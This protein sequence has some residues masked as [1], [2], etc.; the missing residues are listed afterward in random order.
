[1]AAPMIDPNGLQ[2]IL[3]LLQES[4]SNDS[5]TQKNVQI[6]LEQYNQIPDFNS[7][8]I[9]ILT[10]QR[11]Q[12]V[13]TRSLAGLILK[14]NVRMYYSNFPSQVADFIKAECLNCVGDS[15][16]LIRA[17][18]GILITTICSRDPLSMT[19]F[20]PHLLN[21]CDS[22]NDDVV[23][24]AINALQKV[25]E[26]SSQT[27]MHMEG[28]PLSHMIPKFLQLCSHQR[29]KVREL[30]ISAL[31]Q[32]ILD[33]ATAL[34]QH[35]EHFVQ[36]LFG[37]A[38]DPDTGV[39]KNVCQALV[40]LLEVRID[41]LMPQ[42][43]NVIEYMLMSTQDAD[44]NVALESCEFWLAFA[45][46]ETARPCLEP[47][48]GRL[49]PVLV[50]GMRYSEED[51]ILLK[52][53]VEDDEMVPD[54]EED[55]APRHAKTKKTHG[56]MGQVPGQPEDGEDSDDEDGEDGMGDQSMDWNLRKCSAAA[57]DMLASVFQEA[58]LPFLLPLIER[59]LQSQDWIH[60]EC[61]IL[62]LGA[63]SEG[64]MNGM[65][66][67][68]PD[69]VIFLIKHCLTHKRALVRSITC[70]TL[71]RY[72]QWIVNAPA[73]NDRHFPYFQCLMEGL[74]TCV[75]DHN[76]RVQE[77]ACSA[78]ATL[79]EEACTELVPYLD[80]ILERLVA[81]FSKYQ[82]KNLLILYDAIGTLADCVGAPLNH[83]RYIQM[84]MPPLIEKWNGLTDEDRDL[85]PLLECLSSVATALGM[86]FLPYAPR[87]YERCL[88]LVQNTL[89]GY[90]YLDN[91]PQN[92]DYV[93]PDKDFMIVALDLLSGVTE[94]LGQNVESLVANSNLLPLLYECMQ[95]PVAE[96]RQS[97]F[98]L[99]GDLTKAC[100]VHV[101]PYIHNFLPVVARNLDP[102]FISVCNNACWAIGEIAMKLGDEIKPYIQAILQNLIT[103]INKENTPKTLSENC[104]I[105]IGRLGLVCPPDVAPHLELF[106][107]PWCLSL[108]N[109]R[110]NA[111]KDSAFRGVCA[112][113]LVNPKGVVQPF[114]YFCDAVASWSNP[115]DDL[116]A[117]FHRILHGFKSSVGED[118]WKQYFD[119]FPPPLRNKLVETYNL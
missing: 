44:D 114:I 12:E 34:M 78:F 33:R 29:G 28:N 117:L 36:C 100:W 118:G 115:Q 96:V 89:N 62:A 42:M 19:F 39:R 9:F 27:L 102:Q 74:L 88:A 87:V 49:I 47:Y 50:N 98:A 18:I 8:L 79:E 63:I 99:L 110:D 41:L 119:Q 37:L 75:L 26:D 55:I 112:M 48:L 90:K 16:P 103:I 35:A 92:T 65:V 1:M 113:I 13:A 54:R 76:K 61:G 104:A 4:Q 68:L 40:K 95:D 81:A 57:L 70:W 5:E 105:T 67:Y 31:N 52:G 6:K 23:E 82:H 21:Y 56:E 107:H 77:A 32:F 25:C 3:Q 45:D 73:Q 108:R 15:A 93:P 30:T 109:I 85:F 17:T 24:G 106:I 86:G 72:A 84:L 51:I 11:E 101:Q 59:D 22:Q 111:E 14:N 116:K 66:Q 71:S 97:A 20:I 2:Q 58:L 46:Q 94:G 53:D 80:Y 43:N 10:Q 83:P 7:Y 60:Q 64:C 38:T 91:N 69:L